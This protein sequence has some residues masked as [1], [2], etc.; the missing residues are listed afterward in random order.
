MAVPYQPVAIATRNGDNEPIARI[1]EKL[2]SGEPSYAV[3]CLLCP[4]A[5]VA[6]PWAIT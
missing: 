1:L 5:T 3:A 6:R 4:V 2:G